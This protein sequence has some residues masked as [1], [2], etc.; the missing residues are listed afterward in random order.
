MSEGIDYILEQ[1]IPDIMGTN[2]VLSPQVS[3]LSNVTKQVY[4]LGK[5]AGADFR[6]S[7]HQPVALKSALGKS[8]SYNPLMR[9]SG[10]EVIKAADILYRGYKEMNDMGR[11]YVNLYGTKNLNKEFSTQD[12]YA[13]SKSMCQAAQVGPYAF[14]GSQ[15]LGLLKEGYD[16]PTKL[17]KGMNPWEVLKDSGK[18]LKNNFKGGLQGVSDPSLNCE[19]AQADKKPIG[20]QM[21]E[22][23]Y[24]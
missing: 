23:Y 21:V 12:E 9:N 2:N 22:D 10:L 7:S 1:V 8:F 24:K 6:L 20:W 17:L 16:I 4:G 13:H 5:K 19:K 3:N 18:D 11:K 15:V 14:L